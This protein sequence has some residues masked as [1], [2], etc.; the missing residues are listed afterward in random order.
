MTVR[1]ALAVVER[2]LAGEVVL[3]FQTPSKL[4]GPD[5][6]LGLEGVV[7]EDE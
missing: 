4:Y 2:V 7:R 1:A 5:F 6:V 3:G